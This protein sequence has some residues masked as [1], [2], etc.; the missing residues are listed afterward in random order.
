MERPYQEGSE[1]HR[2]ERGR[3]VQGGYHI[4]SRMACYIPTSDGGRDNETAS[5]K[6]ERDTGR[7][8]A[9]KVRHLSKSV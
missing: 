3:V 5:N 9:S 2:S 4:K 6:E 7:P 1:D 8:A